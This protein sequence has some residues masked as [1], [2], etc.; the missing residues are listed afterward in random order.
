VVFEAI[1]D[2]LFRR[3][4]RLE[5]RLDLAN[6]LSADFGLILPPLLLSFW[7]SLFDNF[8]PFQEIGA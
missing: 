1:M 2:E 3:L 8:C 5:E 6:K 7:S 4:R